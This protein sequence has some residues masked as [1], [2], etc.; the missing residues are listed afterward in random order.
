MA[1]NTKVRRRNAA[2]R[3]LTLKVQFD[4]LKKQLEEAKYNVTEY[5]VM[6]ADGVRV[7][8]SKRKGDIDIERLLNDYRIP[9]EVIEQYRKP[10]SKFYVIAKA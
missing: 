10:E 3:W 2:K 4:L 8:E 5:G 6:N 1:I 7:S 9:V